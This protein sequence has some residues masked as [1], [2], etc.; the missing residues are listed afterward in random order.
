M[1]DAVSISVASHPTD[2]SEFT[3]DNSRQTM[4]RILTD[5]NLSPIRS[6]TTKSIQSQSKSSLRRL[7]SKF[8]RGSIALQGIFS[9]NKIILNIA[10]LYNYFRETSRYTYAWSRSRTDS[11]SSTSITS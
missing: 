1:N 4:N 11:N 3:V 9:S 5:V 8:K 7:V 2:G 10:I 6:Q